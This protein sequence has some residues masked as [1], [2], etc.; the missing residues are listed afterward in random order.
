MY[1]AAYVLVVCAVIPVLAIPQAEKDA[2]LYLYDNCNGPLWTKQSGW[3]VVRDCNSR[4]AHLPLFAG[5]LVLQT[6]LHMVSAV[7]TT[8]SLGSLCSKIT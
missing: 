5:R 8:E 6:A 7:A 4:A 3:Y 2:L 1:A